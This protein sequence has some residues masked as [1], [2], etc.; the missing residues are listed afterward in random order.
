M[1]LNA[2]IQQLEPGAIVD[3][4]E[5]DAV[6]LGVGI[7]RFHGYTQMGSIWWQ[8][9]EYSP[10]PIKAE[11]FARV[12]DK[13]PSPVLSLANLDGSITAL[14]LSYGDLVGSTFTRRRTLVKY[15]DAAN[16]ARNELLYSAEIDN[17]EWAKQLVTVTA[18]ATNNPNAVLAA[19]KIIAT[20]VSGYHQVYQYAN[21]R[22]FTDS[23]IV[24]GSVFLKAGEYTS[25]Q[26]AV[27]N[28]AGEYALVNVDLTNGAIISSSTTIT[29][30]TPTFA[31]ISWG[32]GYYRIY[33][34]NVGLGTG[35]TVPYLRILLMGAAN[36]QLF[37]GNGVNG[38]YAWGAQLERGA[39]VTEYDAT[40][41]TLGTNSTADTTQQF[42]DEIWYV[43][44]KTQ[45]D[46]QQVSFELASA[47][48]FN[49]IRLPRRQIISNQCPWKYRS[50]ECGYVGGAV[51]KIDDTATA[52]LI[53]DVCGKRIKSCQ[54]RFGDTGV[55][56]HGGFPAAGLMRS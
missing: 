32:T 42:P 12:S 17:A 24:S 2:E 44:R 54:L 13:P 27:F 9:N 3:L 21:E 4:Y 8:G 33:I 11:G 48:D 45:E 16:F 50:A 22:P 26:V 20:A 25:A 53:E 40:A 18:N 36:A 41:G 51:A 15:L 30:N 47:M 38:I 28:K 56:N 46:S 31:A 6:F 10:W 35:A 49:N 37:T 5:V 29:E 23:E 34:Q 39:A 43:E 55:L 1:T 19:D 14:C 52:V 7:L